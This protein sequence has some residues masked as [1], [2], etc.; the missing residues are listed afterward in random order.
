MAEQQ[1]SSKETESNNM[2]EGI[3][4]LTFHTSVNELT[5][6]CE[7]IIDLKNLKDNCFDLTEEL[8]L[9]GW[10]TYF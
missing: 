9:Q 5:M 1:Q 4:E 2:L 3:P 6:L 7:T 8:R 10:E